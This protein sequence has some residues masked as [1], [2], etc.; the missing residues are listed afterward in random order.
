VCASSMHIAVYVVE[1]TDRPSG[2]LE[3]M[4]HATL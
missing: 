2:V 3:G 1:R 4:V